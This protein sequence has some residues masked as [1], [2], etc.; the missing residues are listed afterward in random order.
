MNRCLTTQVEGASL[1]ALQAAETEAQLRFVSMAWEQELLCR[2]ATLQQIPSLPELLAEEMALPELIAAHQEE[3][4]ALQVAVGEAQERVGRLNDRADDTEQQAGRIFSPRGPWHSREEDAQIAD[5]QADAAQAAVETVALLDQIVLVQL[6]LDALQRR[7]DALPALREHAAGQLGDTAQIAVDTKD[8][9]DWEYLYAENMAEVRPEDPDTEITSRLQERVE[10]GHFDC[11]TFVIHVLEEAGYD[12]DAVIVV[13]GQQTTVRRFAMIHAE[14]ILREEFE[15]PEG[16]QESPLLS[17]EKR[18]KLGELLDNQDARMGGMMT[19]LTL[20]GQG[21]QISDKNELRPG[22]LLQY[23]KKK[24]KKASG[25][26]VIVHE[27]RTVDGVL[28]ET[29][30]PIDAPMIVT[31]IGVLSAHAERTGE[32]DVYTKGFVDPD[33]E[34][35]TWFAVRPAGSRWPVR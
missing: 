30:Q 11:D 10:D 23:W 8:A 20:S 12:L 35:S 18:K 28:D 29:A 1:A 2:Q 34:Y 32:P 9:R 4:S 7:Q 16:E 3:L 31:G 13:E 19:A 33:Q 26:A 14:T 22:D 6:E 27:V 25:H 5:H 17:A 21:V 15:I 24:D